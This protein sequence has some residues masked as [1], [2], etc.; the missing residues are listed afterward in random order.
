MPISVDADAQLEALREA[1][2]ELTFLAADLPPRTSSV[3][4]LSLEDFAAA[5]KVVG[6]PLVLFE[7]FELEDDT[8]AV[9]RAQEIEGEDES[10]SVI[11]HEALRPFLK[12]RGQAMWVDCVVPYGSQLLRVTLDSPWQA[13]FFEA[14]AEAREQVEEMAAM[15][16]EKRAAAL[17]KE[18]QNKVR[19]LGV[20]LTDD[21]EF[22]R[23][24]REARP[25]ITAMRA[26]A[27][28]V[29]REA[30]AG[31]LTFRE[32]EVLRAIA[33]QIKEARRKV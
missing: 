19:V 15:E 20:L 8:F 14:L 25:R 31:A 7:R 29:L 12:R 30:N 1:L 16:R 33:N 6:A 3:E 11:E 9:E 28:T 13:D 2:P 23:L 10:I 21:A 22:I 27:S 17:E 26:R 5:V 4:V 18:H 24:A 32:D